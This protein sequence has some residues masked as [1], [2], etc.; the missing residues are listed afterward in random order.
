MIALEI[1]EANF[2]KAATIGGMIDRLYGYYHKS[3]FLLFLAHPTLYF[4]LFVSISTNIINIYI[5]IIILI[6]I[7]DIFFKIEIIQQKYIKKSIDRELIP[8]LE[9]PIT[10]LM[11]YLGIFIY[12]PLLVLGL[13][14]Q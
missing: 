6:K 2:Q 8:I 4:I 9:M 3:V 1:I 12:V 14:H 11:R 5:I 7:F 13:F 10:P